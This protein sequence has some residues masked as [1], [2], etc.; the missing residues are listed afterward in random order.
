MSRPVREWGPAR[1][2]D[3]LRDPAPVPMVAAKVPVSPVW[4]CFS[5]GVLLPGINEGTMPFAIGL[6]VTSV[7]N[8]SARIAASR[9]T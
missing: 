4:S 8:L 2:E 7:R 3:R 1:E 9:P 6:G 5:L